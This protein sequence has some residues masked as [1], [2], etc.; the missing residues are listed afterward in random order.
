VSG[1]DS[2]RQERAR[3]LMMAALDGELPT[4]E[5]AELD[6]L[7]DEDAALREEWERLSKVKEVTKTMSY[8]EPPEEV[9]EVFWVSVYNR[10]ERGIGWVLI[11]VGSLVLL[12]FGIWHGIMALLADTE[13]PVFVKIAIFATALGSLVLLFSVAREKW[14]VRRRDPYKEIPR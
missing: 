6:R 10:A 8:R 11:S 9:W 2:E 13:L 1:H 12:G 14:F 5:R 4:G 7:L 3:H